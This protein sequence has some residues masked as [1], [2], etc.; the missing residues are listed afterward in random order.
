MVSCVWPTSQRY[1]KGFVQQG[2]RCV[3]YPVGKRMI[4]H[5][6]PGKRWH[7]EL[8]HGPFLDDLND[9]SHLRKHGRFFKSCSILRKFITGIQWFLWNGVAQRPD[10]IPNVW[11]GFFPSFPI[12]VWEIRC[13]FGA[14]FYSMVSV[15]I[16][17]CR[18]VNIQ[19]IFW[20]IFLYFCCNTRLPSPKNYQTLTIIQA[21]RGKSSS[22]WVEVIF[23]C[24]S[25]QNK[26]PAR[27]PWGFSRFSGM[28]VISII[29]LYDM[30]LS[31]A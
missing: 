10:Q 1:D 18:R 2:I 15:M 28:N 12:S 5:T 21:V 29:Y 19:L 9:D 26:G 25:S 16:V 31:P 7:N 14:N 4:K 17:I 6:R 30:F 23:Q 3:G 11:T 22:N 8:E 27:T 20:Q 13:F 24:R